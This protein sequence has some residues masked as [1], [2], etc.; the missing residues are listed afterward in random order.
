MSEFKQFVDLNMS[1]QQIKNALVESVGS[2]PTASAAMAGR[3]VFLTT[4]KKIYYCTGTAWITNDAAG[5]STVTIVKSGNTYTLYQ[6]GTAIAP[7]IDIPKDMVV[8]SGSVVTGT[9]NENVFTPGTGTGKALAL[10]IANGGGTVYINVADLVDAYSGGSTDTVT[11]TVSATN[12]ITAVV[13]TGSIALS[14]LT[15]EA[16]TALQS[17][18]ITAPTSSTTQAT[19]GT[20]TIANLFQTIVNNIKA[21]F[22]GLS[23]KV[24]KVTGK[25]LSTNDFTNEERYKL[26]SL[27]VFDVI[28]FVSQPLVGYSGAI[29][30]E[31]SGLKGSKAP[32]LEAYQGGNLIG[33]SLSWTSDGMIE[34]SSNVEFRAADNVTI[35]AMQRYA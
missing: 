35:V 25:G 4:D 33:I 31:T 19:A 28:H 3:Q 24:D 26:A 18:T 1:G 22:E 21:L 23:S 13:K 27:E 7:T 17:T 2:L 30:R 34:W 12:E 29:D 8:E 15:E 32:I 9:W 6:G 10:V 14:H 11:V 20:K 16:K 5:A